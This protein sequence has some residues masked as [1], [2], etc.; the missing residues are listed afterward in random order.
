[1]INSKKYLRIIITVSKISN[2]LIIGILS[3]FTIFFCLDYEFI[4]LKNFTI[5]T[6]LTILVLKI[7]YWFVIQSKITNTERLIFLKLVYLVLTYIMP[8]YMIVQESTLII[9]QTVLKISFLLVFIF[10]IFGIFIERYLILIQ[11]KN[12]YNFNYEAKN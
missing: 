9:N 8:T 10:A 12:F 4:H 3:I 11:K 2:L 5:I 7:I 6:L 1:M